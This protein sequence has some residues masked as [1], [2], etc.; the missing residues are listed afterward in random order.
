MPALILGSD[1][2]GTAGNGCASLAWETSGI[3]PVSGGGLGVWRDWMKEKGAVE[4][5]PSLD[6][7]LEDLFNAHFRFTVLRQLT[8]RSF[9]YTKGSLSAGDA[10]LLMAAN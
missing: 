6:R 3:L 2:L 10:S 4:M 8:A 5:G 9:K 1:R 7:R